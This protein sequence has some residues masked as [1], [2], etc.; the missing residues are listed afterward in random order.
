[1]FPS[2]QEPVNLNARPDLALIRKLLAH[3]TRIS[4]R[5][6]VSALLAQQN[7]ETW[8]SALL[9]NCRY[10]EVDAQ[11]TAVLGDWR[12]TLD[13]LRGVLIEKETKF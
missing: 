2:D 4:K 8:T 12:L 5:G 6:L 11:G 7:P 10:V 3:S 1:M 9:R 13:P